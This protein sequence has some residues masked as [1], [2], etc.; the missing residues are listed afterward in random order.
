MIS[1]LQL[2]HFPTSF[3]F[4][5]QFVSLINGVNLV[6]F[7]KKM[8]LSKPPQGFMAQ[9]VQKIQKRSGRC[10]YFGR[11]DL[12]RLKALLTASHFFFLVFFF[13]FTQSVIYFLR[14]FKQDLQNL[15]IFMKCCD[16]QLEC[17]QFSDLN[18]RNHP[19]SLFLWF[20]FLTNDVNLVSSVEKRFL[21]TQ[22]VCFGVQK[23]K[24]IQTGSSKSECFGR[25]L[26][27]C[28]IYI[29]PSDGLLLK[30]VF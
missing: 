16:F 17:G 25:F 6:I 5:F 12:S 18:R 23:V 26:K 9:N 2:V 10:T 22:L 28:E 11:L 27:A 29:C 7:V 14:I 4:F 20:Q 24:Q 8:W 1:S 15:E 30:T 3:C 21:S 19:F 13:F